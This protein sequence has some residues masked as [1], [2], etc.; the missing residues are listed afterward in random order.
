MIFWELTAR[1]NGRNRVLWL[2]G[3]VKNTAAA[4]HF[5]GLSWWEDGETVESQLLG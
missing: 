2:P 4:N 3:T 5:C 1:V